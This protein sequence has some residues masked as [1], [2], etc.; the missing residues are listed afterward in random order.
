M[1]RRELYAAGEPFGDCCTR[2]EAGRIIYGGGD[3]ASAS[4]SDV[5]NT[6]TNTDRRNAVSNGLGITGDGSAINIT[7]TTTDPGALKA[8]E[9]AMT[10]AREAQKQ[11]AQVQAAA[12]SSAASSAYASNALVT[13]TADSMLSKSLGF[14]T[15]ANATN[16]EGF[17]RLLDVGTDLFKTNV[18]TF[19]KLLSKQYDS[20][21]NT[22]ALTAQAYQTATAEKAGTIDNK[23][24]VVLGIAGAVAVVFAMRAKG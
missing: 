3:S 23:T 8:M 21:Q 18:G 19:E 15:N 10:D 9:M 11:A 7:S 5:F 6:I 22:Q 16:A 20:V 1:K 14:A 12:A 2:R 4:S 17:S 24:I 13:Q